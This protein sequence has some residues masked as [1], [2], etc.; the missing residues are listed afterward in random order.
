MN[1]YSSEEFHKL[2]YYPLQS[3]S[4]VNNCDAHKVLRRK[5]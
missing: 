4:R 5:E 1:N 3:I 2:S